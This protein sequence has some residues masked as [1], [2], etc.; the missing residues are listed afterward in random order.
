M[1]G[2]CCENERA[3]QSADWAG[4]ERA[5]WGQRVGIL[6]RA[7]A[8]SFINIQYKMDTYISQSCFIV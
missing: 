3:R 4:L 8:C 6:A 2:V 1:S 7:M 5:T